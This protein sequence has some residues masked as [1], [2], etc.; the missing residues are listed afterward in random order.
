MYG[1]TF[2]IEERRCYSTES[3]ELVKLVPDCLFFNESIPKR[4]QLQ[5]V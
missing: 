2:C 5:V 3:N 4:Y 1:G